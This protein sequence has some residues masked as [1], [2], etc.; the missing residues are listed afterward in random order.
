MANLE[1]YDI[2]ANEYL[3]RPVFAGTPLT[4][5]MLEDAA[6]LAYKNYQVQV[7]LELALA[8]GQFE[9]MMGTKGRNPDTNPYNVY[10]YDDGTHKKY[11]TIQEGIND[12]FDLMAR[13]YLS[14]KTMEDLFVNFVNDEG[15]RYATDPE[16]EKKISDQVRYI[17]KKFEQYGQNQQTRP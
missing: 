11:S 17:Q 13:R 2:Y 8:Q 12:Y 9:T 1:D 15:N 3:A 4:G 14:G 7:P 6:K 16:Y 5:Q 10:E